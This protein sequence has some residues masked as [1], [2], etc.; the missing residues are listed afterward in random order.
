MEINHY[1]GVDALESWKAFVGPEDNNRLE[2]TGEAQNIQ[3][4]SGK[5]VRDFVAISCSTRIVTA[6]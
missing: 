2:M 5:I 6:K 1:P 3:S 4:K